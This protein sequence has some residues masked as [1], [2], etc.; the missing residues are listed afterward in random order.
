MELV[1]A[2]IVGDL[3]LSDCSVSVP[4]VFRECEFDG[5]LLLKD[6]ST[7]RIHL[8]NCKVGAVRA[9]RVRC[10]GPLWLRGLRKA[11]YIDLEGSRIGG[12]LDLTGSQVSNNGI[13]VNLMAAQIDGDLIAKNADL[14]GALH[15]PG[16]M[17]S[18]RLLLEQASIA[19]PDGAA[20]D[21][22]AAS[23]ALGMDAR[24][25][26][27]TGKVHFA[28]ARLGGDLNLQ[29]AQHNHP[30]ACAIDFS[31]AEIRGSALL[32]GNF[33]CRGVLDCRHASVS[34][35]LRL[36]RAAIS[37]PHAAS[38]VAIALDW[39]DIAGGIDATDPVQLD[40]VINLVGTRV[41][42]LFRIRGG[43][44]NGRDGRVINAVSASFGAGFRLED[45]SR[46][47]GEV[48]VATCT[49]SGDVMLDG[50]DGTSFSL[51]SSTVSGFVAVCNGKLTDPGGTAL[52]ITT[53]EVSG[54]LRLTD[55][56]VSGSG[57]Q[58][59]AGDDKGH[60]SVDPLVSAVDLS[61]TTIRGR[62]H[63]GKGFRCSG[64]VR[65]VNLVVPHITFHGAKLEAPG[66]LV[67]SGSNLTVDTMVLSELA[68]AGGVVLSSSEIGHFLR[69]TSATVAGGVRRLDLEEAGSFALDLTG[70]KIGRQ[71]NMTGSSFAD[72]VILA[73]AVI[74]QDARLDDVQLDGRNGCAL[75]ATRLQASVLRLLPA[76]MP[77][78][79][80]CL[81]NAQVGLLVD[82]ATSWPRGHEI[83][84]AGFGYGRLSTEVGLSERLS[85]LKLATPKFVP[86][87]YEQL[88]N[89]LIAAGDKDGARTV[90][91]AATRRSYREVPL[92]LRGTRSVR[93]RF[94]YAFRRGWGFL[95]DS[96]LGYGYRSSRAVVLFLLLWGLGGAAFAL[97]SGPCHRPGTLD[98][99][100]CPVKTGE[101]PVWDPFL[102]AL[103]LLIPLLDL[104]HEKAWDVVGLSKA[105]MWVLMVSGWVLATAII[106]AASRT[107]R[108]N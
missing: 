87:P 38:G 59:A 92:G 73:D 50:I 22:E 3:D 86:G 62:L 15:L 21:G 80:V 93:H 71:L 105:V 31:G 37:D 45:A 106:A 44:L 4:M 55:L 53:S 30:G 100:P 12:D 61:D 26:R 6:A 64:E 20:V 33:S 72:K 39:A 42:G 58:S 47:S 34:G 88:A 102:Y 94:R 17:V 11:A 76:T 27:F 97:G 96:V 40:G 56:E 51:S 5:D 75:D 19:H 43:L 107:L 9:S 23:M 77:G 81:A 69:I 74:G 78:G 29:G 68:A 7:L 66:A 98:P 49:I 84:L 60:S 63:A 65:L 90:R 99:G 35:Q 54:D 85:W 46:L 48:R 104:G 82:R 24:L 41:G 28:G 52:R 95:Q 101:H 67:L 89:C 57:G 103:D 36:D 2:R 8:E 79:A 16:A 14:R 32:R 91:L 108:R 83:D 70:T 13:A 1:G 10:E 18:R 25:A